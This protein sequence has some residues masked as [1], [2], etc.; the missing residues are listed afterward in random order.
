MPSKFDVVQS[1]TGGCFLCL[2][3][4]KELY[5]V[6]DIR[7]GQL[8]AI[9]SPCLFDNLEFYMLDNTRPWPIIEKG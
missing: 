7:D 5:I 4:D 6:R 9:C 3:N 2:E 1:E 8:T